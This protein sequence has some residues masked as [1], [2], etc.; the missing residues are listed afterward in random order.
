MQ[1]KPE[2]VPRP[3]PRTCNLTDQQNIPGQGEIMKLLVAA[4]WPFP[5]VYHPVN[6]V[7]LT[8]SH[9]IVY[10]LMVSAVANGRWSNWWLN[11]GK[12]LCTCFNVSC[13][14]PKS[15]STFIKATYTNCKPD[16]YI[17]FYG[18]DCVR[19]YTKDPPS[20]VLA[21]LNLWVKHHCKLV[22]A[23]GHLSQHNTG[24]HLVMVP[25]QLISDVTDL[26]S[27]S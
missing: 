23:T 14:V 3:R 12:I 26:L 20:L 24:H 16:Y 4:S 11:L 9:F 2:V 19:R 1:E 21:Q 25:D 7:I 22:T 13:P 27:S 6:T 15:F 8:I 10:S 5:L 17:M 18:E